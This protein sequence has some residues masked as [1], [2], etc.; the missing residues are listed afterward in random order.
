MIKHETQKNVSNLKNKLAVG[1]AIAVTALANTVQS[2]SAS[3][4]TTKAEKPSVAL[5]SAEQ[6]LNVKAQE[7][8]TGLAQRILGTQ[9]GGANAEQ[10]PLTLMPDS[11]GGQVASQTITTP[12]ITNYGSNQGEYSFTVIST[13]S[14]DGEPQLNDVQ[15]IVLSE[16]VVTDSAG[17][18]DPY[19]TLG[20]N[21]NPATDAWEVSGDYQS[22]EG[23]DT[24]IR[25]SIKSVSTTMPHLSEAQL[26]DA[27]TQADSMIKK[28]QNATQTQPA[29]VNY[30]TPAFSQ[31]GDT[32][33]NPY[34]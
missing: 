33:T 7:A 27:V 17:D 20:F 12:G 28:V 30:L 31:P 16:G 9:T 32:V 26:G 4:N 24:S 15:S 23:E 34:N 22:F 10:V 18:L 14:P 5:T 2:A 13:A 19:V 11:Q 6:A 29:V 21:K 1:G 25:A 3:P 8:M